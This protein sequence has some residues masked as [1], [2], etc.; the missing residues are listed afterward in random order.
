[1]STEDLVRF[2]ENGIVYMISTLDIAR[3][4]LFE[5]SYSKYLEDKMNWSVNLYGSI[6]R[7]QMYVGVNL[8]AYHGSISLDRFVLY[9]R[10]YIW[11]LRAKRSLRWLKHKFQPGYNLYSKWKDYELVGSIPIGIV[12]CAKH[13]GH[14]VHEIRFG[15]FKPYREGL[16]HY[17][18]GWRGI[19]HKWNEE[20]FRIKLFFY[21]YDITIAFK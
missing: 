16:L 9:M 15:I 5:G 14:A 4:P 12:H 19:F 20:Y 3:R 2:T 1:M 21:W 7:F 11:K 17:I 18:K 6:N 10:K 8:F 13:E